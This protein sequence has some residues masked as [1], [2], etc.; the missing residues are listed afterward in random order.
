M[1]MKHALVTLLLGMAAAN[2]SHAEGSYDILFRTGTLDSLEAGAELDYTQSGS[3]V[4]EAGTGPQALG[5]RVTVKDETDTYLDMVGADSFRRIGVFPTNVGNPLLMYAM[6]TLVRDLSEMTGG[7]PFYIRNRLKDAI[8]SETE[9]EEVSVR[10]DAA[11]VSASRVTLYP[12]REDPNAERFP[13][14]DDLALSVDVSESVPGWYHTISTRM[15][16]AGGYDYTITI[17]GGDTQ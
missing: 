5:L 4:D 3:A 9:P 10:F 7:S 12:F 1:K 15:P 16:S 6:E 17:V 11:D 2:N 14:L 8:A 13:G